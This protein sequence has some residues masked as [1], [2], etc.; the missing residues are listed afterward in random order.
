MRNRN[1]EPQPGKV[2]SL[3]SGSGPCIAS[4]NSWAESE[5]RGNQSPHVI[6]LDPHLEAAKAEREAIEKVEK[7]TIGTAEQKAIYRKLHDQWE[8]VGEPLVSGTDNVWMVEVTGETGLTM[9]LGIE[10]DGYCHS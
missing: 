4:G 1:D 2:Y 10:P 5:V 7:Y 9:W 8:E 3:I 6:T